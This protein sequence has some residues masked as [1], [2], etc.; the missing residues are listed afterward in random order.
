MI[1]KTVSV[2]D[3][4]RLRP[5]ITALV[6]AAP[7]LA[8]GGAADVDDCLK[9]SD[10]FS[11]LEAPGERLDGYHARI[12]LLKA[13]PNAALAH[14]GP[15]GV[16]QLAVT[17]EQGQRLELRIVVTHGADEQAALTWAT[18]GDDSTWLSLDAAESPFPGLSVIT[19]TIDGRGHRDAISTTL[20]VDITGQSN[21]RDHRIDLRVAFDEETPLFRNRFEVEPLP[22]QFSQ[23]P[24]QPRRY[25]SITVAALP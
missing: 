11:L 7:M 18:T 5:W 23:Q 6:L 24:A 15:H 10:V 1:V 3:L 9:Q 12:E 22:G 13:D 2:S 19:L 21:R 16:E 17:I 4:G 25:A 8:W 14:C 20:S